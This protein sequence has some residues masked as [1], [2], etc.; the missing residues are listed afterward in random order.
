[1]TRTQ[2]NVVYLHNLIKY[3][4]LAQTKPTVPIPV[5][6]QDCVHQAGFSTVQQNMQ[7]IAILSELSEAPSLPDPITP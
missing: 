3:M 7:C 5:M 1:M 2:S 4:G 6:R